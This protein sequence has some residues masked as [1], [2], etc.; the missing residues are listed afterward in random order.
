MGVMQ[1]ENNTNEN[2]HM[3]IS[4]TVLVPLEWRFY[5]ESILLKWK[6]LINANKFSKNLS[7]LRLC[8]KLEIFIL[9]KPFNIKKFWFLILSL[10]SWTWAS[11]I[12]YVHT[13]CTSDYKNKKQNRHQSEMPWFLFMEQTQKKHWYSLA[14]VTLVVLQIACNRQALCLDLLK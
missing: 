5:F 3:S 2:H 6:A 9:I 8:M 12:L 13:M 4:R 11:V 14:I 7:Y 1:K 10:F